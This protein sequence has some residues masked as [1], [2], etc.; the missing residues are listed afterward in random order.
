[1]EKI[2]LFEVIQY[3]KNCLKDRKLLCNIIKDKYPNKTLEMNVLLNVY[4]IGVL[5]DIARKGSI[6]ELQ[7][8]GYIQK[9]ISTYGLQEQLAK[10]GLNLWIDTFLGSGYSERFMKINITKD[11]KQKVIGNEND[12][13]LTMLSTTTAEIKCYKG[14]NVENIVVPTEINGI[15]IIGIG[16][17]AYFDNNIIKNLII[18][19]G[20]E[21]IGKGAFCGCESLAEVTIPS[22]VKKI[23]VYAFYQCYALHT[24][25]L[26]EGLAEIM[27]GA[28]QECKSLVEVTIP[29]TVEEISLCAFENCHDL[30]TICLKEGLLGLGDH[31]FAFCKSLSEIVIPSTVKE[32]GA[33][34]FYGCKSLHTIYLEEELLD[35]AYYAL[36]YCENISKIITSRRVIDI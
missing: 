28:F 4:D 29:S 18:P 9:L 16:Y 10:Q 14:K 30:H 26:A 1:V 12:Y 5:R 20:I 34:A 7:Y 22:T 6:T 2:N 17:G 23:D 36:E 13:E 32:L 25:H 11:N 21:Y 27:C 33:Q 15:K 3:N 8:S 19:Q 24:V 35:M 31:A